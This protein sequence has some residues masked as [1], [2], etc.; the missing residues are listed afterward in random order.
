MNTHTRFQPRQGFTLI[1]LLV[2]ISIIAL[3]ISILLPALRNA[4]ETAT[5][6]QDLAHMRQL[7]VG[8]FSY[9][10][11]ERG[12]LMY[13]K[14][15]GW[16]H[17]MKRDAGAQTAAHR[18]NLYETFL[19][20]YLG[21]VRDEVMFSKGPYMSEFRT[22]TSTGYLE[23]DLQQSHVTTFF[24]YWPRN[25]NPSESSY[26][27]GWVLDNL[28]PPDMSRTDVDPR[29]SKNA[30][31]STLTYRQAGVM[32]AYDVISNRIDA[33]G[34]NAVFGDGSGSW[35]P[36]ENMEPFFAQSLELWRP[37]ERGSY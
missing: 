19:Y 10:A 26:L 22:P 37:K 24:H 14:S 4:R 7:G 28:P 35:V 30:L 17:L 20:P 13:R 5:R 1:E 29:F 34:C 15:T 3:L 36:F 8:T 2:V 6:L 33:T 21:Y 16:P 31:W 11:D 23:D 32:H 27:S 12:Q 25:T 9:A 18:Y